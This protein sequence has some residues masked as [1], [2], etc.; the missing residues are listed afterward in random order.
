KDFYLF[1]TPKSLAKAG[2]KELKACGLG[3]RAKYVKSFSE[4]FEQ[5]KKELEGLKKKT[6]ADAKKTLRQHDGIGEKVADCIL[7]FSL[8][9]TE[10]FPVDVWI[11]RAMA[12]AFPHLKNKSNSALA[13]FGRN[14]WRKNA[15]I[16]QE[17]LYFFVRRSQKELK[18]KQLYKKLLQKYGPQGWWPLSGFRN[19]PTTGSVK[20]YHP[21]D[22]SFPKTSNQRFEICTGAILTQNT[23][24]VQAEKAL[25]NLKKIKALNPKSLNKTPLT[26][27]TRMIRPAG[28]FNQKAKKL[29]IFANFFLKLKGKTPSRK[30]LLETWGI[31]EETADSMLLYAFKQPQFVVDAYTKRILERT[32]SVK[33]GASYA[34]AKHFFEQQLKPNTP[35]FQEF[36]ALLVEHAKKCCKTKKPLCEKCHLNC[37]YLETREAK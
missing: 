26:K 34:Q 6:Y 30:E 19:N 37:N 7:L 16:A 2:L 23:S 5:N 17:Y 11:K 24:W 27:I 9:K 1:P 22:Y 8:D 33:K 32:K 21:S 12:N 10:A 13:E 28:Y 14:R 31:G 18:A 15:G 35:L 20:G 29:K 25:L 36:H 4:K 3:Y